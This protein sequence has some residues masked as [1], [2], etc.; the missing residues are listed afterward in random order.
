MESLLIEF[1]F[2]VGDLD[3]FGK[4][5]EDDLASSHGRAQYYTLARIGRRGPWS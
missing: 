1:R 2:H 5:G 3:H 4:G